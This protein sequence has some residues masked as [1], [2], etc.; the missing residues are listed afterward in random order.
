MICNGKNAINDKEEKIV[1]D[2]PGYK[3]KND[4]SVVISW[5]R[6]TVC[7]KHN[8]KNCVQFSSCKTNNYHTWVCI[9]WDETNKIIQDYQY[10]N[11]TVDD[12]IGYCSGLK[13]RDCEQKTG[14]F[15]DSYFTDSRLFS[16]KMDHD[17][18]RDF[19]S[20]EMM[21][22]TNIVRCCET[23]VQDSTVCYH[24][25]ASTDFKKNLQI[26]KM[27]APKQQEQKEQ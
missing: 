3:I 22:T 18:T 19:D 17:L 13:H 15:D 5:D 9:V 12:G 21:N 27:Q 10:E 8:K 6:Q 14:Y 11:C 24:F 20:C 7:D 16:C 23:N 25:N 26:V 4:D 2:E 1:W